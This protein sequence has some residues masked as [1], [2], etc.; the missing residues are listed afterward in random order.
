LFVFCV[1]TTRGQVASREYELKAVFLYRFT[2]F[3]DWPPSAF[4]TPQAP[5]IIGIL[6]P[7]PFGSSLQSA[8]RDERV[9]NHPLCVQHYQNIQDVT[10]C[11]VLY[12]TASEEP[13][14]PK[15]LAALKGRST[16]TVGETENFASRGGMIQFIT[17]RNRIRF[18]I[19]LQATRAA[20][21]EISSKLLELAE[22]VSTKQD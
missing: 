14:L 12:I 10:N 19:N 13:R 17:E 1:P 8:I 20:G 7:D 11:H 15:I 3:I 4:P 2:Q 22:I 5:I 16:L 21:F 6:G 9:H 18:R